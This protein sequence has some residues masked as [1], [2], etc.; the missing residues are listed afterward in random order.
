MAAPEKE[1]R[2]DR[3]GAIIV[4]PLGPKTVSFGSPPPPSPPSPDHDP[5]QT[6]VGMRTEAHQDWWVGPMQHGFA[7]LDQLLIKR[8]SEAAPAD[9]GGKNPRGPWSLVL[10]LVVS[11]FTGVFGFG[12][13]TMFDRFE[14]IEE[15]QNKQHRAMV[16]TLYILG[17]DRR[18]TVETLQ[19]LA[20]KL[21][22]DSKPPEP[23]DQRDRL[24]E[25]RRL[26][27]DSHEE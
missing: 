21:V 9:P 3:S 11:A 17:D 18:W 15:R 2:N 6:N 14:A 13:K 20:A 10:L 1:I 16:E 5:G 12:V 8:T 22:P 4:A 25:I 19:W 24:R 26:L 7:L 27:G 23:R